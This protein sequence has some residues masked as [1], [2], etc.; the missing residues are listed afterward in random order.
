MKEFMKRWMSPEDNPGGAPPLTT[1]EPEDTFDQEEFNKAFDNYYQ[2]VQAK[3]PISSPYEQESDD[4][5]ISLEEGDEYGRRLLENTKKIAEAEAAKVRAEADAQV[6]QQAAVMRELDTVLDETRQYCLDQG[7]SQSETERYVQTVRASSLDNITVHGAE[8]TIN[9]FSQKAHINL[10]NTE[11]GKDT[12]RR[13]AEARARQM[14]TPAGRS[15][16]ATDSVEVQQ[17]IRDYEMKMNRPITD[18]EREVIRQL[19]GKIE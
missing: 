19:G 16:Q 7:L 14:A 4:P 6:R 11:L 18:D 15:K 3:T 8:A 1:D 12:A 17:G 2:P 10:V 5:P 13:N 9:A